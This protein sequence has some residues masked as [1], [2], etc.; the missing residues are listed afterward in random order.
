[1]DE[2]STTKLFFSSLLDV[3]LFKLR[4]ALAANSYNDSTAAN[5]MAKLFYLDLLVVNCGKV[6]ECLCPQG[7][8]RVQH[9]GPWD[10]NAGT[11]G[12]SITLCMIKRAYSDASSS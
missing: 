7:Y 5:A 11:T 12:H 2:P 9:T 4:D 8:S 10:L 3:D 1:M 6:R